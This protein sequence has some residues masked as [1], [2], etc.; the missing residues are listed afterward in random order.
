MKKYEVFLSPLAERK[1]SILLDYLDSEW[2]INAKKKFLSRFKVAINQISNYPKSCP[3]SAV[4]NGLFKCVVTKQSSI[5]YRINN[6]EIEIITLID[7]RQDQSQ[8]FREI[9]NYFSGT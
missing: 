4:V 8:L 1:L 6:D 2:G 3:E 7:N 5:Y 9:K